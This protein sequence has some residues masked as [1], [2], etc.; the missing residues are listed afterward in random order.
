MDVFMGRLAGST[1]G[2]RNNDN[3]AVSIGGALLYCTIVSIGFVGSLFVLVP[4]HIQ[5]LS[6]SSAKQIQWRFLATVGASL[7]AVLLYPMMI[8]GAGKDRQQ[9]N[10]SGSRENSIFGSAFDFLKAVV[11]PNVASCTKVLAHCSVLYLGPIVRS[12]LQ[13]HYYRKRLHQGDNDSSQSLPSF[14]ATYY[15][16]FWQPTIQS[17]CVHPQTDIAW[18]RDGQWVTLRSLLLASITEEITFRACI[19]S[20]LE[21]THKLQT[22]AIILLS[23]LYFGFAHVH[24]ARTRMKDEPCEQRSRILL[25][26]AFQFT[27]TTLFGT[28]ASLVYLHTKSLLAVISAHSFCNAMGLPDLRFL[29]MEESPLYAHR[30]SLL[31]MHVVGFAGFFLGCKRF[32]SAVQW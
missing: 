16:L 10:C 31:T 7:G 28:Y 1:V 17:L 11:Q 4:R 24:H 8:G 13:A 29:R 19:V 25:D 22:S 5:E 26:A 3:N 2:N 27:Y 14:L 32:R 6:R 12:S 9:R 21:A 23:P 18:Q 30:K 15:Q 20:A